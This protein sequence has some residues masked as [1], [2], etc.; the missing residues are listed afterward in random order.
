MK[1][2]HWDKFLEDM[3]NSFELKGRYREVFSIRF[4]YEN[5]HKNDEEVW[6]LAQAASLESYKKA[7]D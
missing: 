3:A 2:E 6:Q 5:W 4:A 1:P 7:N